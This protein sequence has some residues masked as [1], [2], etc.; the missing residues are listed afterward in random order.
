M[1]STARGAEAAHGSQRQAEQERSQSR[2]ATL[3]I[4]QSNFPVLRRRRLIG[5]I[6]QAAQH[7]VTLVCGPAGAGKTVACAT[8]ATAKPGRR[9]LWLTLDAREQNSWCW[10]SICAGLTRLRA[11]PP[12]ALR[13]L[14]DSPPQG[15][16]LRLVEAAQLFAEPV[17]LVLDDVHD[18][19]DEAVLA[20]LDLL[21]RLAPGSLRLVLSGRRPPA[22]QLARLRVS[23]E[24]ADIGSHALACTTD[25]ADA[26]FAMLGIDVDRAARDEL[27]RRTEGWMA[28]LRLATMRTSAV[29]GARIVAGG[30]AGLP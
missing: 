5:L 15:F 23:G 20:G 4:P 19:A 2:R 6:E 11:A 21:I 18:V 25:E 3:R 7:R 9:L 22:L 17:V 29:T 8:W 26:Y 13:S 27:L 30:G 28:G 24:L 10:A 14:A 16:P 1:T 12:D